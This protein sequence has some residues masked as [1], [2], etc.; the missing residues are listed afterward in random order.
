MRDNLCAC[1]ALF[2]YKSCLGAV[3]SSNMQGGSCV[4]ALPLR[5]LLIGAPLNLPTIGFCCNCWLVRAHA[6]QVPVPC[7]ARYKTTSCRHQ[8]A[9]Q[10]PCLAQQ[11]TAPDE[12]LRCGHKQSALTFWQNLAAALEADSS[13]SAACWEHPGTA[14]FHAASC[15]W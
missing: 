5:V 15:S 1:A 6:V 8:A 3:K 9:A 10:R 7:F 13:G 11:H 14:T 2:C 12:Q 4:G